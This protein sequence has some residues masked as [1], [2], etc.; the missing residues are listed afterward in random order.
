MRQLLLGLNAKQSPDFETFVVG[1]NAEAVHLLM[2]LGQSV[3][4]AASGGRAAT[5]HDRFVYLWGESGGGKSHLLHALAKAG[6][7]R[8]IPADAASDAFD[9]DPAVRLYLIDDCE[10]LPEREQVDAFNLFNEI[11]E[12]GG[13]LVCAGDRAPAQL[14]VREDLRTRLGWGLIYCIH[15]LTDE[16]KVDALA[17]AAAARGMILS[18]GVLPYLITH[19][20]RDMQSLSAMLDAL[21]R[22][23][24]ET[25]R[26]ITR[27]LLRSLLQMEIQERTL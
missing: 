26:P 10:Q 1:R 15:G 9:Y 22:Y 12:R 20:D 17:Q 11:R 5:V 2:Q 6:H 27:P 13:C 24:L 4:L 3:A 23:S 25:Q 7:G 19:F 8:Y 18:P 16:E 14:A 21:D